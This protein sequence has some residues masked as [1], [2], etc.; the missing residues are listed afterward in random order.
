MKI[1]KLMVNDILLTDS[2]QE[3][4]VGD[5]KEIKNGTINVYNLQIEGNHNYYANGILVHNKMAFDGDDED[6]KLKGFKKLFKQAK[7]KVMGN[8][9]D[10]TNVDKV[11]N[12]NTN[13]LEG[14]VEKMKNLVSSDKN[15]GFGMGTSKYDLES[16][17]QD[18]RLAAI[19]YL[20][21]TQGISKAILKSYVVIEEKAFKTPDGIK[22]LIVMGPAK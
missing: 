5:I 3:V 16:A 18:A 2:N 17:Q 20:S 7:D 9:E 11:E 21:N 8:K 6:G 13:T 14:T 22:Y 1:E 12:I 19:E 10:T 15:L 4:I